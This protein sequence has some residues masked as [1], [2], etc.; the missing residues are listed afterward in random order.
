MSVSDIIKPRKEVLRDAIEGIIDLA[1]LDDPKKRKIEARPE[2]FFDLTYPT[3]DI[4]RV[5]AL[6]DQRFGA[7]GDAPG[8][9]LFEGLKGSGK[10]HLLLLIYHLVSSPADAQAWLARHGITCRLPADAVVVVNKF[11]DLPLYSIWD[12][13]FTKLTGKRPERTVV[14]PSLEEV[15][16]ALGDRRLVLILDEVEQGIRVIADP[17][18]RAQNVAF[19]QML[20]EWGSRTDQV[21]LFASIYSDHEEPGSTLK[22]VPRCDVNFAMGGNGGTSNARLA[23]RAHVVLH[24]LFENYLS[25]DATRAEGVVD[26]Y[27]NSWRRHLTV[28]GDARALLLQ[29]YPF[30]PD[31]LDII[32]RRVPTRGG[33]QNV[34]GAL[35]FL[36]QMVRL[37]HDRVDLITPAHAPLLDRD[38]A[39]RLSD[40]DAGGD[41]I[42]HAR[43]NID[44]LKDYPL[45]S[46]ISSAT[47]LYTLTGTG[48]NVGATKEEILRS[49]LA[50]AVDINDVER[51]LLA[52]QKYASHFHLQEGRY[53][54]DLEENA[55]AKVEFR[56]LRIDPDR[57][58]SRDLLHAI[59]KD[60]LFREPNAV[61]FQSVEGTRSALESLEK[62]RL[63]YV[64]A[65]RRLTSS[66]RH[67]LYFGVSLRNQ[68]V[69]LEPKDA[70]FDLDRNADLL[71]WAQRILAAQDLTSTAREASRKQEYERIGREDRKHVLDALRRAGLIYVHFESYGP[72]ADLDQIEEEGLGASS[73]K[74]DVLTALSQ[75]IFPVQLFEEH[76][77]QRVAELRDR[78][79]KDI[80]QEYRNTIGFPVP[81]HATSV[82]KAIRGLAK[83]RKLGVCHPKGNFCGDD[84]GLTEA[85][86][87]SASISDP[88][89]STP[90]Q[91]VLTPVSAGPGASPSPAPPIPAVPGAPPIVLPNGGT[92]APSAL[93]VAILPQAS[94]ALLRQEIAAKLTNLGD[95][96]RVRRARFTVFVDQTVGDLSGLPAPLRGSLS[97]P[98]AVAA[99]ITI[100]KEGEFTKADIETMAERL[101]ALA[102]AEY[103]ARLDVTGAVVSEGSDG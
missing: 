28:D 22:R 24:R 5:L 30:T 34:R 54:F 78:T 52:F 74:D 92:V 37:H 16:T 60:E 102:K 70:S 10:S 3:A 48:R 49:V 53:F 64:L 21:T 7:K 73:A 85:E 43:G 55:D 81:T 93:E 100:T 71:K 2:T 11:T 23:D 94:T 20:S 82:T 14:Q 18:V 47:M 46:E 1:N 56:S 88:F 31:L 38:I 8:L 68:V 69:L 40:L 32:L 103:G 87:L 79:V 41:L 59:W 97:G 57:R 15:R 75:R 27:L 35:G 36:G 45:A 12:F 90:T 91:L 84:P 9:F 51:T 98:G 80:D 83:S 50:P 33:F 101:P 39:T 99:D 72:S 44:E 63:R 42:T 61:V 29:T 58:K 62:D 19:L 26:S 96:L 65:P 77:A 25:F 95:A 76:L 86:I 89:H 66:E 4:R 6:L 67:D 13:V 17:A